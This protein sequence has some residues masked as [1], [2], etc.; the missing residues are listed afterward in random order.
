M[1]KEIF[2]ASKNKGKI[3]EF[4]SFFKS[5]GLSV[6]SLLDLPEEVDVLEDGNTFEENAIKK[7]E[8]IGKKIGKP[9][10]ADDSGLEVDAL[11][12]EPG[13]FSARY[14][15]I[16][17]SDDANNEK[18]LNEL[19][20]IERERRTARFVCSLAIYFPTGEVK[21]VR[22]TCEGMIAETLQGEHGFGYDPLFYLPDVGM[23]MAQLEQEEKNRRSHRANAL[24]KLAEHWQ[25]W[26]TE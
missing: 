5:K 6:K 9:V 15:G 7:A 21:T 22:G 11:N 23:S 1:E 10:L 26:T 17:K 3:S 16:E 13:I 25:E 24:M 8:T 18:L 19:T 12:G 14:A 2:I 4:E 20:G